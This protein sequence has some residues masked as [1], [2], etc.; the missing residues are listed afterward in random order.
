MSWMIP[1][2]IFLSPIVAMAVMGVVA[3]WSATLVAA[4]WA[5]I[6]VVVFWV[7]I[8]LLY[9]PSG[10]TVHESGGSIILVIYGSPWVW[11]LATVMIW[12]GKV[13]I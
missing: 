7:L 3:G 5:L 11:L 2:L 13:V 10:S 12:A 4:A 8:V 9:K 6:A 1:W